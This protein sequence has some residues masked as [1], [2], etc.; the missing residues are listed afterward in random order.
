MIPF[1]MMYL[2]IAFYYCPCLE[3]WHWVNQYNKRQ[4]RKSQGLQGLFNFNFLHHYSES[5]CFPFKRIEPRSP[6]GWTN[7]I[8][9]NQGRFH[10]FQDHRGLKDLLRVGLRRIFPLLHPVSGQVLQSPDLLLQEQQV[11][12]GL[13]REAR[14]HA[15]VRG[16][17]DVIGLRLRS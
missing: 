15:G 1:G 10:D 16:Q 4:V 11:G 7:N 12:I 9:S 17:H 14:L 13:F 3:A 8:H 6:R 5:L 2:P